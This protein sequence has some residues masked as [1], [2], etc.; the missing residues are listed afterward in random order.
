MQNV[1]DIP[2]P[3]LD[4]VLGRIKRAGFAGADL[5]TLTRY[6]NLLWDRAVAAERRRVADEAAAAE[7]DESPR[8]ALVQL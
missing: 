7:R 2:D 6:T 5:D 1:H 4:A 3:A 8:L